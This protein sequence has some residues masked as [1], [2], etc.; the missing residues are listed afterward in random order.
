MALESGMRSLILGI[1]SVI[2]S[3]VNRQ[4]DAHLMVTDDMQVFVIAFA[5]V[6]IIYGLKE[7]KVDSGN[8]R[9]KIGVVIGFIV[10]II[11]LFHMIN[12]YIHL[13]GGLY[14]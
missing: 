8:V 3:F 5:V 9:G 11:E 12:M 6:A 7:V 1:V 4:L 13:T 10:I 2:L 14:S